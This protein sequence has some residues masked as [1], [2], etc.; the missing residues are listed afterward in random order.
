MARN[1]FQHH[2]A[3]SCDVVCLNVIK[4]KCIYLLAGKDDGKCAT[5]D[6]KKTETAIVRENLLKQKNNQIIF[7]NPMTMYSCGLSI[8]R[9]AVIN[10]KHVFLVWPDAGLP[11]TTVAVSD[12]A[13]RTI[14]GVKSKEFL[15]VSCLRGVD[16]AANEVQVRPR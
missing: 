9:P 6:D 5:K 7:V 13:A 12:I 1:K 14:L 3:L 16:L 10:S 2:I 15:V 8:L 4:Q 11:L